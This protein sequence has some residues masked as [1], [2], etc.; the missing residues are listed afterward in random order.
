MTNHNLSD[1]ERAELL[2]LAA[3]WRDTAADPGDKALL[4]AIGMLLQRYFVDCREAFE[5][6]STARRSVGRMPKSK[7]PTRVGS[8]PRTV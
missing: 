4:A 1:A 2:Q 3:D 6:V 7:P 5:A 8:M